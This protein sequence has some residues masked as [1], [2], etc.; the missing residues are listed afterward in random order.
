MKR[1][2]QA[3]RSSE[4]EQ[5]SSRRWRGSS[6]MRRHALDD[7]GVNYNGKFQVDGGASPSSTNVR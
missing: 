6:G 4:R 7:V 3:A 2:G 1:P 5:G